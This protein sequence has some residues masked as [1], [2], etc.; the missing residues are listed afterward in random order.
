MIGGIFLAIMEMIM[1][2]QQQFAK[3]QQL[4]EEKRQIEAQIKE[5]ERLYGVKI[6]TE[7][8]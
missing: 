3:K 8:V 6:S 1:V 7:G 4:A 5:F 2:I